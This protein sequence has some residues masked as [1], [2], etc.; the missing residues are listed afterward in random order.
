[1]EKNQK[2][3]RRQHKR[4]FVKDRMF[5]VVRSDNHLL[6]QIA[7]LSNG[8]IAFAIMKSNP[9]KMGEI[10]DISQ[11]GLSFHYIQNE[12]DISEFNEMDILFVDENFHLCRIPFKA[13]EDSDIIK[14]DPFNTLAMKRLTVE[15]GGLTV[16]QKL[17][18]RH[19]IKNF[20][21]GE[22]PLA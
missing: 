11:S 12:L 4:Y 22:V 5:A 20:T 9:P 8:Q 15:F 10:K 18:L 3:D 2:K 13:V 1:M 17:Q 19:A 7:D 16:K 21:T 6:N 14:K